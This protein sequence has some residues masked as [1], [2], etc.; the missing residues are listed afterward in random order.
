LLKKKQLRLIKQ[1]SYE[2]KIEETLKIRKEKSLVE[3][4]QASPDY[5]CSEP[6]KKLQ[7]SYSKRSQSLMTT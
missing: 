4:H 1:S 6:A 3:T 7:N 5:F 2:T